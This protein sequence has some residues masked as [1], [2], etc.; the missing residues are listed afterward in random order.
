MPMRDSKLDD[1]WIAQA[2]AS[3][4]MQIV[5]ASGNIRTCP[6]RLMF[7]NI[8]HPRK[9]MKRD[10]GS[11]GKESFNVALLFPPGAQQQ[12]DSVMWPPAYAML[13]EKFGSYFT[14]DGKFT[15]LHLPFHDQVEKTVGPKPYKGYTPGCQY[16]S[17]SSEFKPSIVDTLGNPIVDESRVYAGVWALVSINPYTYANR[18][19]GVAYGLNAVMII[20]DDERCD[21]GGAAA[22]PATEFAGV[23]IDSNYNAAAAFGSAPPATRPPPASVMPPAQPVGG[24]QWQPPSTADY[25]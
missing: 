3:N 16:I 23:K 15:G 9:G 2:L 17:V 22:D 7:P 14:P 11:D 12:I 19:K 10:D 25:I 5:P 20:Q 18:L 1:A 13:R 8:F 21:G 24:G 4:P 6:V